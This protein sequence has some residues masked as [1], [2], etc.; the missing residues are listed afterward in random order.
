MYNNENGLP[1]GVSV[2]SGATPEESQ[3]NLEEALSKKSLSSLPKDD[4]ILIHSHGGL[5]AVSTRAAFENAGFTN[6]KNAGGLGRMKRL[7]QSLSPEKE[8]ILG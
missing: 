1:G 4:L 7:L 6:A 3:A 5:Y 2:P 8:L